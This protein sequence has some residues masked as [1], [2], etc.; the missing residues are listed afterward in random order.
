MRTTSAHKDERAPVA[1]YERYWL[2]KPHGK[3]DDF[4]RKWPILR[5]LIPSAPGTVILD[6]GCGNGEIIKEMRVLN[7]AA[8]FVGVDVS[9]AALD[10]ARGSLP[11]VAFHSSRDGGVVPLKDGAVD[12]L[13]CT[14]VI[15]HVYDTE[16]TF[17]EFARL[18]HPGGRILLTTPYHGMVKNLLLVLLAFDRH[19]DPTGPHIRFFSKRSLFRCLRDVRLVPERHGY[20]GRVFP[21]SMSM[22]VLARRI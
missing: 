10:K 9:E 17:H 2:A 22:Y 6:Y 12:F 18:L 5:D 13:L 16:A 20:I 11:D 1:F 7:P 3:L 15:E 19:F 8:H 4:S 14:E 21:V